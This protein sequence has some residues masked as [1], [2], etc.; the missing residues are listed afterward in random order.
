MRAVQKTM[1]ATEVARSQ[2]Y[3]AP[4]PITPPSAMMV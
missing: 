2:R 3:S 4:V 1:S